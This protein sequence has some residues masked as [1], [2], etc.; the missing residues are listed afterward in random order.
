MITYKNNCFLICDYTI[1]LFYMNYGN[2]NI[3]SSSILQ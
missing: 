3:S 2:N 1:I